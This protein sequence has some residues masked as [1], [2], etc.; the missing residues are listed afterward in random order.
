MA[1]G[2][3]SQSHWSA[4]AAGKSGV[5]CSFVVI[6]VVVSIVVSLFSPLTLRRVCNS[7]AAAAIACTGVMEPLQHGLL[8]A[9][10]VLQERDEKAE[11][12]FVLLSTTRAGQEGGSKR[13]T[14]R[15]VREIRTRTLGR[16]VGAVVNVEKA[17]RVAVA[18]VVF[19]MWIYTFAYLT[20]PNL[21]AGCPFQVYCADAARRDY[22]GHRQGVARLHQEREEA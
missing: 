14:H 2:I 8:S 18:L 7:A 3:Y 22:E 19:Y 16:G 20:L 13:D 17:F 12:S 21:H 4:S 11:V 6:A 1:G 15:V 10:P 5:N 9:Y